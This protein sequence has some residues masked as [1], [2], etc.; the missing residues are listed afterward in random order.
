MR[1]V[2]THYRGYNEIEAGPVYL[3]YGPICPTAAH[4]GCVRMPVRPAERAAAITVHDASPMAT[5]GT[6]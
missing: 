1:T 3:G 2:R 6:A 4:D 5:K